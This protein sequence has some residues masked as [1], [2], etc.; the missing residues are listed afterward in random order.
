MWFIRNNCIKFD[1]YELNNSI[2]DF[3]DTIGASAQ[4]KN[5]LFYDNTKVWKKVEGQQWCQTKDETQT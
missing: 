4:T 5:W 2:N 3:I 1:D